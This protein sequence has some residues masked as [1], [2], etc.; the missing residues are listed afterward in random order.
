MLWQWTSPLIF[1]IL[2]MINIEL[3]QLEAVLKKLSEKA[4]KQCMQHNN[5]HTSIS[6]LMSIVW[7]ILAIIL[8]FKMTTKVFSKKYTFLSIDYS[9]FHRVS[10]FLKEWTNL[11]KCCNGWYAGI[12]CNLIMFVT[13][14]T[15]IIISCAYCDR[16]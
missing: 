14:Y 10:E 11:L 13:Q 12:F 5:S 3:L 4:G 2:R 8:L 6:C 7:T 15:A 16:C 9:P 1:L